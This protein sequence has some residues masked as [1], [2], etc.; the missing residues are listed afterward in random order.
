MSVTG[1][2][3]TCEPV[4]CSCSPLYKCFLY[5]SHFR[6]TRMEN[7]SSQQCSNIVNWQ[8]VH[9]KK[10]ISYTE[11]ENIR[12]YFMHMSSLNS[13]WSI[14][15]H[16]SLNFIDRTLRIQLLKWIT[17]KL[18][19]QLRLTLKY[20]PYL[21]FSSKHDTCMHG[22]VTQCEWKCETQWMSTTNMC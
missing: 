6:W 20:M 10:L 12:K 5:N 22:N 1:S 15:W 11:R 13:Y 21:N 16:C 9:V 3:R 17:T 14:R 18:E 8:W 4:I 7:L 2:H 19:F